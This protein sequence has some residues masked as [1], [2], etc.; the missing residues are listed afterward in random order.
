MPR[1]KKAACTAPFVVCG[2]EPEPPPDAVRV[3]GLDKTIARAVRALVEK[4][5]ADGGWHSETYGLLKPGVAATA[6][7]LEALSRLPEAERKPHAEQLAR[8]VKFLLAAQAE[9]GALG[10]KG[11][12]LEYPTYSTALALLA[13]MRL[14]PEGWK[15]ASTKMAAYLR[16][17]QHSE[18]N[19]CKPEDPAYGGWGP[20]GKF[21]AGLPRRADISAT[22]FA[23]EALGAV[24]LFKGEPTCDRTEQFLGRHLNLDGEK[25]PR[26]DAGFIFTITTPELNKAGPSA[27]T[28]RGFLSYAT[29]TA[30][31]HLAGRRIPYGL[32]KPSVEGVDGWRWPFDRHPL[33][34]VPG[35][36]VDDP[37]RKDWGKALGFYYR[38]VMAELAAC[39]FLKVDRGWWDKLAE[40]TCA[41]QRQDGLWANE[42]NLMKED[43][44]L[45]ASP[46]ALRV[47]ILC[48][49]ALHRP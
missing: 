12:W 25:L 2:G 23:L 10:T 39:G 38:A 31:A 4:Q 7:V 27:K 19:G 22:R 36:P 11:E 33:D 42:A 48:R 32:Q 24:M 37:Q 18:E 35:I 5:G 30:D 16:S 40:F 1:P 44:P 15:E 6:F 21:K 13:W 20:D 34:R 47:L 43:D 3:E 26:G 17:A 41:A 29:P 45:I 49:Q 28:P 46:L 8:A 9:D 14:K